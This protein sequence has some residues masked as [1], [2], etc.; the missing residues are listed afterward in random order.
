MGDMTYLGRVREVLNNK[1]YKKDEWVIKVDIPEI[2]ED[3]IAFPLYHLDEPVK[4]D[5]VLL[6]N[7]NPN[8]DNV[9]LYIPLKKFKDGSHPF[10]GFR[11]KGTKVEIH[12]DGKISIS[13]EKDSLYDVIKSLILAILSMKTVGGEVLDIGTRVL[14][15]NAA[16]KLERLMRER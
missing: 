12:S 3:M 7:M 9:F 5:E 15:N 4:D 8:L 2:N 1:E 14:L 13:N 11:D 6:F 16:S 10:T